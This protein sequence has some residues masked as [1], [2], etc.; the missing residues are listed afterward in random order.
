MMIMD[1]AG[2]QFPSFSYIRIWKE[3]LPTDSRAP[4]TACAMFTAGNDKFLRYARRLACS[5]LDMKIPFCIYETE[6]VHCSISPKGKND[7]S[8]TK[9]AC[10]RHNLDRFAPGNVLYLDCD[11]LFVDF[12]SLLVRI[13]GENYDHAVYNWLDDPHN[14]AY[15]PLSGKLDPDESRSKL[16]RYSHHIAYSSTEQLICSGPV[17]FYRNNEAARELVNAWQTTI[18]SYPGIAD[19]CSMDFAYNNLSNFSSCKIKSAWLPKSYVRYP[20][21]PYEKPV[22]LHPDIPIPWSNKQE[23]TGPLQRFYADICRVKSEELLFPRT[24]I[25]DTEKGLLITK[26]GDSLKR[27]RSPRDFWIHSSISVF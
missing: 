3:W 15:L 9:A 16:Y 12:P 27:T 25:I 19:D 18:S 4:F 24:S 17:Q 10:I 14:E 2:K 1:T 22:I 20:W 23:V 21:W 11:V 6:T 26:E 5:C 13:A 8:V 7:L